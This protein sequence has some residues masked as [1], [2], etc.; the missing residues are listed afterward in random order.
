MLASNITKV[1]ESGTGRKG[2]QLKKPIMCGWGDGATDATRT[3][4]D[5]NSVAMYDMLLNGKRESR[6]YIGSRVTIINDLPTEYQRI[7]PPICL[8]G[9]HGFKFSDEYME[10]QYLRQQYK[11][12][13]YDPWNRRTIMWEFSITGYNNIV[14]AN[15]YLDWP[16]HDTAVEYIRQNRAHF[17]NSDG[18]LISNANAVTVTIPAFTN[19]NGQTVNVEMSLN[20]YYA[21]T[22]QYDDGFAGVWPSGTSS[23]PANYSPDNALDQYS[24][25]NHEKFMLTV[26]PGCYI[27]LVCKA[28]NDEVYWEIES[29]GTA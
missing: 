26:L 8:F 29:Y 14:D 13:E 15:S 12:M 27:T 4:W 25:L 3:V 6:K 20:A 16:R 1:T 5:N 28:N 9:V 2:L 19:S 10:Y 7:A 22:G 24:E 18:N 21:V 23:T 11:M 17:V